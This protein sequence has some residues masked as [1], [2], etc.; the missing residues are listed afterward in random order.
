MEPLSEYLRRIV[1]PRPIPPLAI[2]S[3]LLCSA[4]I[5]GGA[6]FF[7][8]LVVTW[9]SLRLPIGSSALPI[10]AFFGAAV[11][12][13][14]CAFGIL[15]QSKESEDGADLKGQHERIRIW[16]TWW[17]LLLGFVAIF[18]ASI[19]VL[20]L[21]SPK[22]YTIDTAVGLPVVTILFLGLL[23]RYTTRSFTADV[24]YLTD[25]TTQASKHLGD[26]ITSASQSQIDAFATS[27]RALVEEIRTQSSRQQETLASLNV[28]MNRV[29]GLLEAQAQAA[30]AARRVQEAERARADAEEERRREDERIRLQSQAEEDQRLQLM[31]QIAIG[32][33][34]SGAIFHHLHLDVLNQ[35]RTGRNVETTISVNSQ[36]RRAFRLGDLP[37]HGIRSFDLGDVGGF[38]DSATFEVKVSASDVGGQRYTF[39]TEFN[40]TRSRGLFGI[41]TGIS[42]VPSGLQRAV[43]LD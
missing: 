31:P 33:R 10:S 9:G 4:S 17:A 12:L 34:S 39:Q 38:P 2:V 18:A 13:A 37:A 11:G 35:G 5:W 1:H 6:T 29:S 23:S 15:Q 28:V 42:I 32:M 21:G 3:E 25:E 16:F 20:V 27:T 7:V 26:A 43:L 30:E 40:Y 24:R 19:G 41:T 14:R 22:G 36:Q 8:S